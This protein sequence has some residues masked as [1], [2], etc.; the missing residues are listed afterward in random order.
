MVS[1]LWP[2]EPKFLISGSLENGVTKEE[3][4]E[5]LF[6]CGIYAGQ[7][8]TLQAFDIYR[9]MPIRLTQVVET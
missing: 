2:H 6:Y 3:V 5:V 7:D 1:H 9:N 8:A 4:K